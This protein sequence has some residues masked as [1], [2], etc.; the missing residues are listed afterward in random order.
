MTALFDFEAEFSKLK[1]VDATAAAALLQRG[2]SV[3]IGLDSVRRFG[4]ELQSRIPQRGGR[5]WLCLRDPL[6]D[7]VTTTIIDMLPN[8]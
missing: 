1:N 4:F 3:G 6:Q 8:F 5:I 2:C 7:R